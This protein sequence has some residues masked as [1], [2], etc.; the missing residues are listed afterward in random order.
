MGNASKRKGV[1]AQ[2]ILLNIT[3]PDDP[4]VEIARTGISSPE[5]RA[6]LLNN[7]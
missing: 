3:V 1:P 6:T 7:F 2:A 4:N 5:A